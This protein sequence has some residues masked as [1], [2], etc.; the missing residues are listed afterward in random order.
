MILRQ[1]T[2]DDL[3]CAS[4]L[5]GDE[6]AGVAAVVDPRLD[7]DEYLHLAR[8]LGVQIE[9]ILETHNHAD[10]VSGHGRLVAATGATIHIHADAEAEYDHE[11]FTD[12]WELELG[13]IR[14]RALHTPGHRPEHTAFALIDTGRGDEPW[15]VLTGDSLFVGDIARPDLA[16]DKEAGA[17]AIFGSLHDTLLE[18]PDDCEVWPGHVGGSL[19][20]GPGMDMKSSTTIG[21]ERR[22]QQLLRITNRDDFVET[23]TSA[24]GP[25]P[26]NFQNIVALNRGPLHLDSIAPHPLAP[27]QV[28]ARQADGALVVDVRTE[29]QFDDAHIPG[30]LCLTALRAG[31][32]SKLAW[33]ADA[34]RPLVVVGRDDEDARQAVGLAA[35]VGITNVAGYLAGGMTSWREEGR[36]VERT[37]RI[38]LPEL[39]DRWEPDR[40]AVQIL[41]VREQHEWNAGHIPGSTFMP[42]HDIDDVPE[43]LY[44]ERPIAVVC[45]SGQR[46]AVGASLIRHFGAR[47][48][49]HVVDGGVPMWKRNG[50][51]T[52]TSGKPN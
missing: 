27:R 13:T 1:I 52:E 21:F 39:H 49:I 16:I 10:H 11:P 44:P 47:K 6:K 35:A 41:D 18:L 46:A 34:D 45:G 7:I 20:G 19:C 42:Y 43:G 40:E 15:A 48:V 3:G 23:T 50:W 29:Q 26:P 25:Q 32:G 51:P 4:Y 17:R 22:H 12:G 31:F 28:A 5:V 37:D 38:T 33:L 8:Y 14:M 36:D 30:A 2:H 9:H 24:L